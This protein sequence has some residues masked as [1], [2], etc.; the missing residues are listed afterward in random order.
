MKN[1][2]ISKV[3]FAQEQAMGE[4]M[5]KQP[6]PSNQ[7]N[8]LDP[9]ILLHHAE[10]EIPEDFNLRHTGVAPHPHRG[11]APVTFVFEGGI[12]HQDSR[13]NKGTVFT[14]GVQWMH[15]GMGII[16]SERPA[17][18][19][20]QEIIQ[21]WINSPAKNKMDQP[22][23]FPLTAENTPQVSS[24]DQKVR[25]SIVS[26]NLLGTKGPIP[27]LT[28]INS[29]MVWAEKGGNIFIPFSEKHNAFLYVLSGKVKIEG[30]EVDAENMIVFDKNGEGIQLEILENTRALFMSGEPIGENI[31][32][33]G[34]FVVSEEIQIMEAYRDYRMGKMGIL[35][36]E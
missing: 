15:A 3:V 21:M 26:G 5:V 27:T 31:I 25:L 14:G 22:T 6:L 7:V 17:A 10:N 36:E 35:I 19:G 23:Y 2:G 12:Y 4:I 13:G 16:H 24:E 30:R 33:K 20:R 1:R 32:A 18:S 8:Y 34:P 9:F 11:F 29:A 28:E